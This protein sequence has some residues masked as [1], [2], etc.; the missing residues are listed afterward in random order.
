MN[1]V[2]DGARVFFD[3]IGREGDFADGHV[4]HWRWAAPRIFERVGQDIAGDGDMKDF[5]RLQTGV[6]PE[7]RF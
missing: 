3:C 6:R 7:Y 5:R 1:R 4:E 2:N